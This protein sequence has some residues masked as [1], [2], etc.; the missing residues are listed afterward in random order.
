[1]PPAN[2]PADFL[3]SGEAADSYDVIVIGGGIN[4]AGIARELARAGLSLLLVERDD[5]G[6]G[7]TWRSSKLIH[8]GLRYLEHAEF[9]LVFEALRDRATLLRE[10]PRMVRPLSFLLP[11]YTEDRHR[12]ATIGL[13]LTLYD[14]LAASRTLPRH[15]RLSAPL[16]AQLEPSL[17]LDG[18]SAAFTYSDSQVAYPERLCLATALD[19]RDAGATIANHVE[20]ADF[21][22][23]RGRISGTV[24]R[25]TLTGACREVRAGTTVNATGPWVD[26]LLARLDRRPPRQLGGTKGAHIAVDYHGAGPLHT[27]YAESRSDHRPFFVIPWRDRHLVGT[28]DTRWQGDPSDVSATPTDI[29]YLLEEALLLLPGAPLAQRDVLYGYAGIRPLAA[30][31]DEAEGAITRRHIIRDH[32]AD[33]HPGLLSIVGG[34]LSTY[35]SLA[36]QVLARVEGRRNP[37][38]VRVNAAAPSADASMVAGY[39]PASVKL[40]GPASLDYLQQLY[41]QRLPALLALLSAEPQLST[42]LCPHGP[43]LEAQV[44]LAARDELAVTL[45]DALLRRTAVGWNSC[46]GRDCAQRAAELMAGQRGWDATRIATELRNYSDEVGRT[47]TDNRHPTVADAAPVARSGANRS[48]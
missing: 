40:I 2:E 46:H 32:T 45:S 17:R 39:Q 24:L 21:I 10:Y 35:R 37:R 31:D 27:I 47:F 8:G 43:D 1:M 12:A 20:V 25:S 19:A 3:P 9:G 14:L 36:R 38:A 18:L 29:T 42:M 23:D 48:I 11:I 41:G 7:T 16:A 15:R 28:T 13:G 34:K 5:F 33:G 44:V 4:G 26:T 30:S 6:F 22:V